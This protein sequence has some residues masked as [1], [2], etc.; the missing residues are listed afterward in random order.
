[1]NWIASELGEAVKD[2]P[3]GLSLDI[4]IHITRGSLVPALTINASSSINSNEAAEKEENA[5]PIS[6]TI[7]K[8]VPVSPTESE[9]FKI[10]LGRPDL[11][12]LVKEEVECATGPVAVNGAFLFLLI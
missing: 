5:R 12:T 11:A 9:G 10:C 6:T 1:M 3:D 4:R 2:V 7:E 8:S